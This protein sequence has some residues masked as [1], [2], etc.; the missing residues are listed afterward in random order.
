MREILR[1]IWRFLRIA[2]SGP[3]RFLSL[4]LVAIV[5][6]CQ[7]AGIQIGLRL[8]QW[9]ADFYNA[10]Q[11]LDA[12]AAV[13]Q[14]GVFALLIGTS[15]MLFLISQYL[16]KTVQLRWRRRLTDVLLTSWTAHQAYWTL[17]P[18]LGDPR[19][20]DNPDQRV[21][22]DANLFL[23]S[24]LGGEGARTGVLD[25]IMNLIGLFSYGALLWQL[26]TF[27][28]SF[29]LFGYD[30]VIPKYMFWI[31]PVYVVVATFL[32]H[33][34]GRELPGLLAEEQ[35][36][37]ANFRFAL[38]RIRENASAIAM[39]GGEDAERRILSRRFESVV[40]IWQRVIRRE[41][42]YGL[43]QR[44]Y[45]QTVLRIPM[46]FALPAFLAGKVTL[47]GLMQIA[48]AFQNVVTT[49]SWFIFN[50]KFVSDLVATTRRL[51][52]FHD[53]TEA[54]FTTQAGPLRST[55]V[56]GALRVSQLA[57]RTPNGRPLLDIPELR[58]ARGQ[59]VWLRGA[60]GL[61]KSTLFK[62]LAGLWPHASGAV[63][64]PQAHIFFLPQQVYLPL[65]TLAAAAIY[66]SLPG[67]M[68]QPEIDALL[69]K[70]GLGHRLGAAETSGLSIGEQQR[71]AL[72]RVIAAK[73]DWIFL[74]EATSALDLESE[75]RLMTLLRT[76]LPTAT[77]VIVAHR[78]P[79]GLTDVVRIELSGAD[80]PSASEALIETALV[81]R[82]A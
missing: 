60:S 12:T 53:A 45:F 42:I 4:A 17:D 22:E 49:L 44:P 23:A 30:V 58:I 6:A 1:Q 73:P 66:P 38:M 74:D 70:V 35:K 18:S 57:I 8:I 13:S 31:A 36:R 68:A 52:L 39:S 40:D 37:E 32:T 61:G 51:A 10:L 64:M 56:D 80:A 63:E 69:H 50:Y 5:V 25:F 19:S 72:A 34:L 59:T 47:G 62:A 14:M 43:F 16:R 33:V 46:F 67:T 82:T 15:A 71:L 11:K 28:L 3:G 48:Q 41:F 65:D 79:Q 75:H 78:E 26:S 29:S 54:T 2:A 9:Y 20:V 76:E 24:L 81:A 27:D 21:S 7:L 77:F 55:S